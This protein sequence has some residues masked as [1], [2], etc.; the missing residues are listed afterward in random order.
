MIATI[1]KY[2]ALKMVGRSLVK[3][4]TKKS[5]N[6]RWILKSFAWLKHIIEQIFLMQKL[7]GWGHFLI[8]FS[9]NDGS[10]R[11]PSQII[12][13]MKNQ[14]FHAHK[15]CAK[16]FDFCTQQECILTLLCQNFDLAAPYHF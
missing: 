5:E 12:S 13:K 2:F 10:K 6:K 9:K 14:F 8:I 3:V 7:F 16:S 11:D 15:T 4:L 1:F